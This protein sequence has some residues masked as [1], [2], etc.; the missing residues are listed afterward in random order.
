MNHHLPVSAL[1]VHWGYFSK[2]LK[3]VLS[4]KS[5]DI[6]TIETLTH[7]AGDDFDRMIKGDEAAESIYKW[8]CDH[9]HIARRGAGPTE[10]NLMRG[11]GEG[12]GVHILT[13]PIYVE[14]AAP[15]DVLE[16]RILDVYPRP[17]G[18]P[19]YD[20]NAYGSNVAAAWGFHYHD[21]IEAPKPREVVTVYEFGGTGNSNWAKAVYNYIWTPQ[22]DPSGVYHPT[23]NYPGVVVDPST[24]NKNFGI[25]EGIKV[26]ARLHFGAMGVAPKEVDFAS[27]TPPSYTGGNVDDWRVGKGARMY[28]P[29]AVPGAMFSVGDPHAAQGDSELCGTAIEASLTGVFQLVLHKANTL[30][31]TALQALDYPLLETD[32]E[33]VVHGFSFPNY[34]AQLGENA[35]QKV[36]E[37]ATIDLAMRDAFRKMRRFLMQT[38]MLTEDEAISLL[39]VAVDFGITQVVDGNWGVHA[40]LKKALFAEHRNGAKTQII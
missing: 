11:I 32:E 30:A 4:V 1:T 22:T 12:H 19:E 18:N 26:P 27:S 20:G 24:V 21:L 25:L 34:L 15:G 38:R 40:T 16:V 9:Q 6:V 3:P 14:G 23:Y 33:W 7:H 13:G 36:S 29:V 31:G 2:L 37:K 10:G 39:S 5:G 8:D 35:D 17:S 28:Y